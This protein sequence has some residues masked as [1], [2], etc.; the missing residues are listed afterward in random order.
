MQGRETLA[1]AFAT[2]FIIIIIVLGLL[3]IQSLNAPQILIEDDNDGMACTLD[4]KLCPDGT[5]VGRN[6]NNNCEFY[7]CPVIKTPVSDPVSE[8]MENI[9]V[10]FSAD[11]S[12]MDERSGPK[13]TQIG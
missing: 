12:L 3:F 10:R 1:L 2:M 4:A 6:P 11:G 9:Q 8:R 5:S 13:G 7:N